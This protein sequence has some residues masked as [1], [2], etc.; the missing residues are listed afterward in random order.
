[1]HLVNGYTTPKGVYYNYREG[2]TEEEKDMMTSKQ[3][4][5]LNKLFTEIENMGGT[6][7]AQHSNFASVSFDSYKM[8]SQ[9]ASQDIQM[10]LEIKEKMEQGISFEQ[11]LESFENAENEKIRAQF[12]R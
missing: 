6:D 10:C 11:A 5:F 2:D 1:M 12:N 7:V 4:W 9:M 3:K 8:T